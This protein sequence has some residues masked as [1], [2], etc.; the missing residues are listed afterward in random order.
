MQIQEFVKL[1]SRGNVTIPKILRE[2]LGF[3]ENE[4]VRMKEDKGRLIVEPVRTLSYP[5]RSYKDKELSAFFDLDD[6][7]TKKLKAKSLF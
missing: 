1:Q 2:A 4:L 5:V 7:E 6:K 3:K